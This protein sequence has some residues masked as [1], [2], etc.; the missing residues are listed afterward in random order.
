[1]DNPKSVNFKS[2]IINTVCP[3]QAASDRYLFNINQWRP[4]CLF[5]LRGRELCARPSEIASI[6]LPYTH[7]HKKCAPPKH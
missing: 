7:L 1:M 3:A 5:H 4:R 6:I 2:V